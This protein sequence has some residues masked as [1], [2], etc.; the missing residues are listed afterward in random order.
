MR[1]S[2]RSVLKLF[3]GAVGVAVAGPVAMAS[4]RP[5]HERLKGKYNSEKMYSLPLEHARLDLVPPSEEAQV[6]REACIHKGEFCFPARWACYGDI[7]PMYHE[8]F[9]RSH[10]LEPGS[11]LDG[12]FYSNPNLLVL[13]KRWMKHHGKVAG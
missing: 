8:A 5:L 3:A 1:I 12:A 6:I 7:P 4:P 2:R 13:A 9:L 10:G 11:E